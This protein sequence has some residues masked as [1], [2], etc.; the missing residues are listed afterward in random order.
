MLLR[1][2]KTR[3]TEEFSMRTSKLDDHI[4][5]LSRQLKVAEAKVA[6][7]QNAGIPSFV[8][9]ILAPTPCPTTPPCGTPT[10][11]RTPPL[12]AAA[13]EP[14]QSISCSSRACEDVCD[15]RNTSAST[16]PSATFEHIN[17]LDTINKVWRFCLVFT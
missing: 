15:P 9:P 7:L 8:S 3:A 16:T 1:R 14:L 4:I 17:A 13:V 11:F 2:E 10:P 5:T 12:S 6:E